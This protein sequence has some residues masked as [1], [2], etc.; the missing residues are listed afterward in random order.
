M[1]YLLTELV[2]DPR[3]YSHIYIA[4]VGTYLKDNKI[5]KN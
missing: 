4:S 3:S 5:L 1:L 2:P